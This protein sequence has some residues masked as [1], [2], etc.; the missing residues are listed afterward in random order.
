MALSEPILSFTKRST[1]AEPPETTWYWTCDLLPSGI[2]PSQSPARLF[3]LANA[4]GASIAGGDAIAL[5]ETRAMSKTVTNEILAFSMVPPWGGPVDTGPSGPSLLSLKT[6]DW[7]GFRRDACLARRN[8]GTRRPTL[9][10][11]RATAGGDRGTRWPG[12]IAALRRLRYNR[13][14]VSGAERAN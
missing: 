6:D 12:V 10:G 14:F 13:L 9:F 1:T 8:S 5:S 2:L 4:E 3:S 11:G 7:V